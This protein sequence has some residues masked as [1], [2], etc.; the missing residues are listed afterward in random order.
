MNSLRRLVST[1]FLLL[2]LTAM[3]ALA[4]DEQTAPAAPPAAQDQQ[5]QQPAPPPAAPADAQQPADDQQVQQQGPPP[6][7]GQPA[8][9]RDQRDPP[10]RAARLQYMSGSVSIQPHGTDDWVGGTLNRPL[11]NND[12]V[13]TDKDSRAELN[14]GTGV[15][16]M[17]S[18]TSL[19]LTNV[20]DNAMQVELHQGTVSL[21]VRH[22]F[23]G[24]I[25]EVD[26]PNMAFTVQKT[27][28]YRFQVD[29]NGD[30]SVVTVWK[31]EGDATGSG[32]AVRVKAH[33][34]ARF[35][36]GTSMTHQ[37]S[38]APAFDGFDDWCRVRDERE[39]H[40]VSARY[41]APGVIGSEDLDAYGAWR[42]MPEYGAVWVPSGVA[43]GWS[44]YSLGHWVW[45][46]PW[47]WTW[48]DDEP[49]GF[50][51]YHYGRWIYG[52][53]FWGWA[54]G[55]YYGRPFYAPALVGWF[56]GPRFGVGFGFGFGGG[57]GWC[58]LGW[59]EPFLPW[60]HVSRGYFEHV[61]F[62]NT[63]FANTNGFANRYWNGGRGVVGGAGIHY[64]NLRAPGGAIAVSQRTLTNSLPVHGSAVRMS[65]SQ[66]EGS[67]LGGR[68]PVTPGRTSVLGAN[69]SRATATAP[70]RSFARPV[71][72]R[73]TPPGGARANTGFNS[74]ARGPEERSINSGAA[75]AGRNIPRPPQ[76]GA[77]AS[78]SMADGGNRGATTAARN[79]VPRPPSAGGNMP[80]G[81]SYSGSTGQSGGRSNGNYSP[82][83]QSQPGASRSNEGSNPG[84]GSYVPRPTGPVKP[85]SNYQS[86]GS[87]YSSQGDSSG[88]RESYGAS[89]SYGQPR[90]GSSSGESG[91]SYGEPSY[92]GYSGRSS[93]GNS[94]GSIRGYSTP[95]YRASAPSSH[96]SYGGG[97]HSSGGGGGHSGGGGGHGHGR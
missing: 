1:I 92:R 12:N 96:G 38:G 35:T 51:P 9:P 82:N 54:P 19:T 56:G 49:W 50:A 24:E 83:G 68:V 36:N 88:S 91:R 57:I 25:Y 30:A 45:V 17:S 95:S 94:S 81:R 32:P 14:A 69:A 48:V 5:V 34:Q 27:G 21:R 39:D 16:R 72:S 31:G 74:A 37:V 47:G 58:P 65:G 64:A 93:G 53:G 29:P 80:Q 73:M 20:G 79:Y 67:A 41:V 59:G 4:Q 44:P 42:Q 61:N 60:Y 2:S 15:V 78:R 7:P 23:E 10:S 46:S 11:T 75:A 8:E 3:T 87:R 84:R 18:E 22:L 89:R 55:P 63:R 86:E 52:G 71:A 33:E 70:S 26:T 6:P 43:V 90:Y 28:E 85:A 97:G 66:F 77:M 13:W 40:S 62:Y 76:S